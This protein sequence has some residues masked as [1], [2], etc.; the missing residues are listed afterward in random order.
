MWF[1]RALIILIGVIS[2]LWLGMQ[3][4]GE[5]VDFRFFTRDFLDLDLNLFML[6]V[7]VAGMV[8]SFLIAVVSEVQLRSRMAQYRREAIRLERELAALRNLPL[9]DP[10]PVPSE[11][12]A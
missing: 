7:F 3:N 2:L 1:I 8:F 10:E 6:L 12:E 5:K 4:A 9:D 11:P